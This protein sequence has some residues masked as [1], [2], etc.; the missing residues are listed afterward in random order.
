MHLHRPREEEHTE[1]FE[2]Q[3]GTSVPLNKT[4]RP[5][6]YSRDLLDL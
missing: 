6:Q 3:G 4:N 2:K 1:V 5:C